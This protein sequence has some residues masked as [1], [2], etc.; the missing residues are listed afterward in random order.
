MFSPTERMQNDS[1]EMA[2][3]SR[4]FCLSASSEDEDNSDSYAIGEKWEL[5]A[6]RGGKL[7]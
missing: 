3:D 7:E 2:F 4:D 5:I 6:T 1:F